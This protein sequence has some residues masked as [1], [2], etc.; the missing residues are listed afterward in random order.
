VG[1][2]TRPK[3]PSRE[4]LA[5]TLDDALC[6]AFLDGS[7]DAFGE[8]L[9]RH[10]TL[11]HGLVRRYAQGPEDARDLTQRVFLRAFEAARRTLPRLSGQEDVPF[12]AWLARIAINL[13]KSHAR[14][15]LRWRLLPVLALE[16]VEAQGPLA[17]ETLAHRE[18]E[19]LARKAVLALPRRQREVLTLRVDGGLTFAEIAQTLG[20]TVNN[21]KV[22]FHH[23]IQRLKEALAREDAEE[24][25]R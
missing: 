13:G 17:P 12:K 23:A 16:K 9:R 11:V 4:E 8:I 24:P 18:R 25:R 3:V 19:R 20:M 14:Q 6:R 10:Q 5:R 22:H 21:A 2:G 7:E 1:A 15:T